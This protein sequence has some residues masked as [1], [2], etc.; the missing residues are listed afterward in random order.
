MSLHNGSIGAVS[1]RIAAVRTYLEQHGTAHT[2]FTDLRPFVE[3]LSLADRHQLL[4]FL[5]KDIEV[6]LHSS[7]GD[8]AVSTKLLPFSGC[9]LCL[10]LRNIY[11]RSF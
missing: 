6:F 8:E 10:L 2:A 7:S 11:F 5:K 1:G 4:N 3:D 9:S